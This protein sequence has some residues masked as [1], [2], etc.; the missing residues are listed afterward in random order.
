MGNN[1]MSCC[2]ASEATSTSVLR[3]GSNIIDR[4]PSDLP[5]VNKFK[6]KCKRLTIASKMER[7]NKLDILN[8][9][10][11]DL[12]LTEE[13]IKDY[14]SMG[15]VIG[16]GKY[17]VVKTAKSLSKPGYK[18]A[19]KIIKL[20]KLKS[21]FHSVVQEILAL[22]KID[23]PNVVKIHEIFRDSKKLYIVMEYVE[24]KE[25]FDFV[26]QKMK[27]LESE[28]SK[29]TMQLLKTIKYLNELKI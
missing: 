15:E 3:E 23:H 28:A 20:D 5:V 2:T 17:G 22:K 29:I 9:A 14:Y 1:A 7:T 11:A 18:V 6:N 10:L 13:P 21:Q 27:L 16:A 8:D 4:S 24:G 19:V 26:V 25:L 12:S